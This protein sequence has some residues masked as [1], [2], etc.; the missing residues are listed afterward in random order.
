MNIYQFIVSLV[1]SGIVTSVATFIFT[2]KKYIAE[3]EAAKQNN[4]NEAMKFYQNIVN[5]MNERLVDM[6]KR[7]DLL[8]EN[9][10]KLRDE[11]LTLRE[12][13]RNLT[14]KLANLK[15]DE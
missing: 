8:E 13:N 9:Y 4:Y 2:R 1:G 14:I 10:F 6:Q 15:K 11:M 3:V 12:E 5:D 7:Y